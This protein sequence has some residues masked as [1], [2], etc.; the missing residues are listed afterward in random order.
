MDLGSVLILGSVAV[1]AILLSVGPYLE[2][3]G[4]ILFEKQK[5]APVLKGRFGMG[6]M[7]VSIILFVVGLVL[8]S[9]LDANVVTP[10]VI[11]GYLLWI[12]GG[13][14]AV[15]RN[16]LLAFMVSEEEKEAMKGDHN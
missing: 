9:V 5:R 2:L 4:K 8:R 13:I 16:E 12:V 14:I 7:V 10:F 11:G 3:K 6:L 15:A 1:F